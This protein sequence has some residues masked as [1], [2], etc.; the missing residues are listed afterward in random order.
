LGERGKI[1]VARRE[2]NEVNTK[3][4]ISSKEWVEQA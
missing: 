1:D 4:D 2:V 3:V